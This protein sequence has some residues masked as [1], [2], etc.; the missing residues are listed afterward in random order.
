LKFLGWAGAGRACVGANEVELTK[1]PK[2]GG[3]RKKRGGGKK[4]GGG[5]KNKMGPAHGWRA[6]PIVAYL[7]SNFLIFFNFLIWSYEVLLGIWGEWVHST[8][9]FSSF[10]LHLEVSNLPFLIEFGDFIFF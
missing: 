10:P 8:H 4:N 7:F 3:R 6:C 5:M 2:S 1:V 9:I